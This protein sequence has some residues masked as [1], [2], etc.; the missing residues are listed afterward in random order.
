MDAEPLFIFIGITLALVL[1]VCTY[2]IVRSL[3]TDDDTPTDT[4]LDSLPSTLLHGPDT[5][6][7]PDWVTTADERTTLWPYSGGKDEDE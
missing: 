2:E 7:L 1:I 3:L 4:E 5:D 6:P